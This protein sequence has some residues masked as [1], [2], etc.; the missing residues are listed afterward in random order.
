[1]HDS[2]ILQEIADNARRI[3][4]PE[5]GEFTISRPTN[6]IQAEIDTARTRSINRDLQAREIV[7]DPYT[8][9]SKEVP[10]F[11][12]RSA[13][14]EQLRFHGL[15]T[16]ENETEIERATE[17]YRNACFDLDAA[18]YDG[19]EPLESGLKE[20]RTELTAILPAKEKITE[21]IKV[22]APDLNTAIDGPDLTTDAEI[23]KYGAAREVLRKAGKSFQVD[24]LL[25]RADNLHKLCGLYRNAVKAQAELVA[26][27]IVELGL[28][29]DTLEARA[30]KAAQVAKVFYC[31]KTQDGKRPWSSIA[32]LEQEDLEKIHWLLTE[33]EKF[34]RIDPSATEEDLRRQDRFNFLAHQRNVL[35]GELLGAGK[36][37]PD[38]DSAKDESTTSTEDSD[39]SETS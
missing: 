39:S 23:E 17:A 22:V 20:V 31:T 27:R 25:E 21:A 12:T 15:W 24:S 37:K 38:G 18:G 28:F 33:I 5:F 4:H 14:A 10:A 8:G 6:R 7:E 13:K 1:M 35:F 29:A 30:D 32:D 26:M 9:E 11:L 36:P 2:K 16:L 3:S 34:E 19:V